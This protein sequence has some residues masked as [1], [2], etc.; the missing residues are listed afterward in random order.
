[1]DVNSKEF[2]WKNYFFPKAGGIKL[3]SLG[4]IYKPEIINLYN[5]IYYS[6]N[7]LQLNAKIKLHLWLLLNK[8]YL[9]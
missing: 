4:Q 8:S 2:L 6:Y 3:M 9:N 1:M 7:L 5:N